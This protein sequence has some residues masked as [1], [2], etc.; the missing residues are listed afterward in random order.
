MTLIAVR[1]LREEVEIDAT[2]LKCARIRKGLK[3]HDA[4][5]SAGIAKNTLSRLEK[6]GYGQPCEWETIRRL[7][8]VYGIA[9]ESLLK[10]S[11]Q[12]T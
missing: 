6:G 1:P 4:A 7:C 9:P 2:E 12:S 3:Q 5:T 11:S 10:N 8:E